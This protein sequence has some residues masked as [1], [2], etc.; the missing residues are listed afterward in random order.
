MALACVQKDNDDK[1]K[2][3]LKRTFEFWFRKVHTYGGEHKLAAEQLRQSHKSE[4]YMQIYQQK[5]AR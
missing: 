5:R 1:K 4:K 3:K 2:M